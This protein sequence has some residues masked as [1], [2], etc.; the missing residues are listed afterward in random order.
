ML[1]KKTSLV[2]LK[3]ADIYAWVPKH[4]WVPSKW[5]KAKYIFFYVSFLCQ[6]L[7]EK[8]CVKLMWHS[9]KHTKKNVKDCND[10]RTSMHLKSG[11]C[12]KNLSLVSHVARSNGITQKMWLIMLHW[13]C[14]TPQCETCTLNYD[15]LF[16][17]VI[18]LFKKLL[19][20]QI[21]SWFQLG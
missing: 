17:K 2:F 19:N 10:C 15:I 5:L 18:F 20:S 14:A 9:G 4:K 7:I 13:K 3:C 12:K 11:R 6:L 1:K 16:R 8:W 21:L